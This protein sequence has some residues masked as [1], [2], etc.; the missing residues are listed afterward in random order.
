MICTRSQTKF[1]AKV[2]GDVFRNRVTNNRN[3][4]KLNRVK[5]AK[6]KKKVAKVKLCDTSNENSVI[7]TRDLDSVRS[8]YEGLLESFISTQ[9]NNSSSGNTRVSKKKK[10]EEETL[11]ISVRQ[12]EGAFRYKEIVV[13]RH[14]NYIQVVLVPNGIKQNSL[15]VEAMKELKDAFV[16]AKKDPNCHAVLLN[17]SGSYF[18][19]GVDLSPLVGS[20][21]K[22][23]AEDLASSIRDLVMTLAFFTK[24][25]VAAVNGT[26]VGFGVSLLTYCDVILA[27]DKATFC[28]PS[29][30]IGYLPEGGA[31]LTLPQVVGTSAAAEL[32]LQ[33]RRL[34]ADEAKRCGLVSEVLWPTSLMNDVMPRLER[35]AQ[36][37]LQAMEAT[38][39]MVRCHLW[40]KLK[41]HMD[42]ERRL[43]VEHWLAP[44]CQENIKNV[45]KN[46]WFDD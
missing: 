23:A 20:N 10:P 29:A 13:K 34:T 9:I 39:A 12:S 18:C 21:K 8:M 37:P 43:L 15:S 32:F 7:E 24:P 40:G 25:V 4:L 33:G 17:S 36:Q 3:K 31:T 44:Q 14:K 6:Q 45:L 27:S 30:K 19:T 2:G 16:L 5:T 46:G 38:K 35:I 42:H 26:A 22:Q 1:L 41:A 28:L 11:R